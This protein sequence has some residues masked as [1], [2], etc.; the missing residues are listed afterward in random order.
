MNRAKRILLS[1]FVAGALVVPG[2]LCH[3]AKYDRT[4]LYADGGAPPPPP[5]PWPKSAQVHVA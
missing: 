1:F 2:L 3:T 4:T 5:L